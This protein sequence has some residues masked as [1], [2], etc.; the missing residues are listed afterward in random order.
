[1]IKIL[2]HTETHTLKI[3]LFG[4]TTTPCVNDDAFLYYHLLVLQ[5]Q[6]LCLKLFTVVYI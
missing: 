5:E 3:Y 6:V 2:L 1:M 4:T